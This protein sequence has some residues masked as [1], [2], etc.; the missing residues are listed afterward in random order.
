MTAQIVASRRIKPGARHAS[1]LTGTEGVA[2]SFGRPRRAAPTEPGHGGPPLRNRA[3]EG[4]PYGT[5]S[6]RVLGGH[7][8]PPLLYYDF[9]AAVVGSAFGCFVVGDG[10]FFAL[11]HG[12]DVVGFDALPDQILANG[13]SARL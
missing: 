13:V 7:G 9:D 2:S 4:R 5:G 6:L 8:G 3:T 10:A 11:A 1:R 12:G